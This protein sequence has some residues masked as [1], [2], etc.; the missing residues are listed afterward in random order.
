MEVYRRLKDELESTRQRLDTAANA[1][2][3]ILKTPDMLPPYPDGI[4]LI[5]NVCREYRFAGEQFMKAQRRLVEFT[6]GGVVL[7]GLKD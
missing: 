2:Q 5:R 6:T 3:M 4:Q 7:G 1:F